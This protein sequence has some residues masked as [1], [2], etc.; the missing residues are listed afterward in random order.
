M[1]HKAFFIGVSSGIIVMLFEEKKVFW[2]KGHFVVN[3][4]NI[5]LT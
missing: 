2:I 4:E 1:S 5:L 3:T